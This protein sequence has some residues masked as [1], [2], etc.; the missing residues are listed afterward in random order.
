M[1]SVCARLHKCV[2]IVTKL[3]RRSKISILHVHVYSIWKATGLTNVQRKVHRVACTRAASET[4]SSLCLIFSW[5]C[6]RLRWH[7]CTSN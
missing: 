6:F 1:A 3:A 4:R 2:T 7:R 5:E